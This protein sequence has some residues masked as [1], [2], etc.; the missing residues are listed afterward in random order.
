MHIYICLYYTGD[1][2]DGFIRIF[3]TSSRNVKFVKFEISGVVKQN[4]TVFS[5]LVN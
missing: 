3:Q 5:D 2:F 4:G 1:P